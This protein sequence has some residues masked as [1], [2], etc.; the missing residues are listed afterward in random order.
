MADFQKAPRDVAIVSVTQDPHSRAVVERNEVELIQPII[1]R[2]LEQIGVQKGEIDFTCSGSSDYLAGQAFS[3]VMTL[4]AVGAW[5]P[6]AE[7]HVEMDGA[8][9]LYEAWVKIQSGHADTALVY[10]Y[11]KSSPGD[12]P[13]VARTSDGYIYENKD[14]LDRVLFVTRA[15]PADFTRMVADGQWPDMSATASIRPRGPQQ[16]TWALPGVSNTGQKS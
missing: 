13:L 9:A 8:W 10:S 4:D 3:F 16:Y 15:Q 2:A 6:I 12:L 1:Q 5:P 14:A 7:S 11:G